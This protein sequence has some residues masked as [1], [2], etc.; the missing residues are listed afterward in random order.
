MSRVAAIGTHEQILGWGLAGVSLVE[1][2]TADEVRAAWAGLH[3]DVEVVILTADAAAI[4]GEA[5]REPTVHRLP[6]VMP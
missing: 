4:L 5:L 2:Q 6:V 1:A 3:A